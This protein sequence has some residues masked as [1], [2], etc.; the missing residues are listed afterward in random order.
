MREGTAA[1]S[2]QAPFPLRT[3]FAEL[4]NCVLVHPSQSWG[5]CSMVL[6]GLTSAELLLLGVVGAAVLGEGALDLRRCFSAERPRLTKWT[7]A[8]DRRTCPGS[9]GRSAS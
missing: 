9:R 8:Q 3:L 7:I 2:P 1:G 5:G 6:F 4:C